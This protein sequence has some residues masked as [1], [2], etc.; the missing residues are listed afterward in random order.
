MCFARYNYSSECVQKKCIT[1]QRNQSIRM[2]MEVRNKKRKKRKNWRGERR[3]EKKLKGRGKR[4]IETRGGRGERGVL[5]EVYGDFALFGSEKAW[6]E[7]CSSTNPHPSMNQRS[8]QPWSHKHIPPFSFKIKS[9][10]PPQT[11]EL[12]PIPIIIFKSNQIPIKDPWRFRFG[13]GFGFGFRIWDWDW[14]WDWD[15][16]MPNLH[17]IVEENSFSRFPT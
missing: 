14:V 11:Q 17:P 4:R 15:W 9:P 7:T 3:R 16:A 6:R 5:R 8:I 12:H 10:Y 13:I 1:H 2:K